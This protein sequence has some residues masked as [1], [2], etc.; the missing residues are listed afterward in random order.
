[1]S[2]KAPRYAI[3]FVPPVESALYRFGASVLGYDSYAGET[4]RFPPWSEAEYP[5]WAALVHDARKY[6]FHA[7]LKAPFVLKEAASESDLLAEFKRFCQ[8]PRTIPTVTLS[9]QSLGSF[10]ALT[11]N[12][13]DPDLQELASDCVAAFDGFRAPLSS[14]ERQRRL[15][16][17]L[18]SSQVA[19]LEK[20][21]YPYVFSEFRF[22]MTLTGRISAD[23]RPRVISTLDRE[24]RSSGAAPALALER[25][26]LLRQNDIASAF[27]VVAQHA[28]DAAGR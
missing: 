2:V 10:V 5:S 28:I 6:G 15:A 19:N 14:G 11:T 16:A 25:I 12:G 8:I 13:A 7:T 9:I 17:P 1:M 3:Y 21:G 20:W 23:Q 22:H 26:S 27:R 24:F 4:V 18:S